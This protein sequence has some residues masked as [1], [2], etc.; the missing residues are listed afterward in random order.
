MGLFW[1][2]VILV[3]VGAIDDILD[4]SPKMRL[5][6]QLIAAM[7]IIVFSGDILS[8]LGAIFSGA[9]VA[10]P[11]WFAYLLTVVVVVGYINAMNM[12]DGVDGLAGSLAFVQ[13]IFMLLITINHGV[14]ADLYFLLP[15]AA[16]LLAFLC[17]NAPLPF[18]RHALVFMG[19]AGSMMLGFILVWFSINASQIDP[20][21]AKPEVFLWIAA[22]PIFEIGYAVLRRLIKGQS[23][24]KPDR[25][26]LHH[27][28]HDAGW[29]HFSIAV[30]E[31]LLGVLFGFI[32]YCGELNT[33]SSAVLFWAF[34][35]V[36]MLYSIFMTYLVNHLGEIK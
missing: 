11:L 13:I 23:P 26:H 14:T 8:N 25:S 7:F 22:L 31:V 36:F 5:L 6:T 18:R 29:G 15:A 28:L 32:G 4:I 27:L 20:V 19:D 24:F 34:V 16:V 10:L 33:L 17:F 1:G 3:I 21:I 12:L 30:F 9:T 35:V 2:I